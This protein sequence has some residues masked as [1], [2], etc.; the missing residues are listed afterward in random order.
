MKYTVSIDINLPRERMIE[1]FDNTENMFKWQDCLVSFDHVSGDPG[2]VG[3]ESRMVQTMGKKQIT[4]IET[5]TERNFPESFACTYEADG[6]WN[7]VENYFHDRCETTHWVMD[8]E[9][10]CTGMM[11]VMCWLMPFMFKKESLKFMRQF[12]EFAEAQ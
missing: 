7:L 5:I 1:L 2:Q 12:K 3:A 9:F 6:V 4:M 10:R 8:T 11:K